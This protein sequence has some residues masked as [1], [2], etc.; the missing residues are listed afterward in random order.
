M[1]PR[2]PEAAQVQ[3]DLRVLLGPAIRAAVNAVQ[4][5]TH[6]VEVRQG[7]VM[8]AVVLVRVIAMV[9]VTVVDSLL[10]K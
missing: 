5:P 3:V 6:G 10:L 1:V 8:K 2:Q 9:R 7:N 4:T